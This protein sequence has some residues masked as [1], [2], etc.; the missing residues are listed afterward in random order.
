MK[1]ILNLRNGV[2]I[3][4]ALLAVMTVFQGCKTNEPTP[5]NITV[6]DGQ[7]NQTVYANEN[8]GSGG[9]SFTTTGAW[10]SRITETT[11]A[12]AP[13][14]SGI[15][16]APGDTPDWISINPDHGDAAGTYT[17]T[18]TLLPNET[19]V[20]RTATIIISCDGTEVTINVTQKGVTNGVEPIELK[21]PISTNTTLKD[22]G[23][24]VDYFF[25]GSGEL[26]VDNNAVLTIDPGV[27]IQFR[28][29]SGNGSLLIKAGSTIKAV[30][31]DAK[32]IRF[33][34]GNDGAGSWNY[35]QIGSQTD[36][37]FA[38]CDFING[39]KTANEG[40][41]VLYFWNGKAGISHCKISGGLGNGIYLGSDAISTSSF[42][43]FDN[44]V[45]EGLQNN[46]APIYIN[47][48]ESFK[49]AEK[50]D[51]TSDFTNNT[52]KYIRI[53]PHIGSDATL[54]QTTVPYY[55]SSILT[56]LE[57]TLTINE[58]VTVYLGD[59]VNFDCSHVQ[60]GRLLIN[61][62]AA[63]PVKFTRL[64]GTA[65][66]WGSIVFDGLVGSVIK[67]AIFEYGGKSTYYNAIF[68]I[69][70]NTN[71]TLENVAFNNS[72][73]Y[74]VNIA[75]NSC[76]YRLTHTNVTFANNYKGNVLNTCPNPDVVQDNLP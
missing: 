25:N 13:A 44:N 41:G 73:N 67:N 42:T 30:G 71:L 19:G 37:Q 55:I 64:P 68:V 9:V 69:N 6:T 39:G 54:N 5:K 65:Q 47:T 74:G 21:S 61:G 23:I 16:R 26:V 12:K 60:A 1:S 17:I 15:S 27:T 70:N 58:G 56:N 2:K 34:G 40:A 11:A 24:A 66:F 45:I 62:T 20:N 46:Y 49:V 36:N 10:T 57:Y 8:S 3:G 52:N 50:L 14:E 33:I 18:I 28:N 38:Y 29:S 32:H 53:Y 72:N 7:T 31:S 22:L 76:D 63:K 43:T 48:N 59:N 35:V 51:M 4:V 75:N